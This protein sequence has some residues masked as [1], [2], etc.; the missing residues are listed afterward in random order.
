MGGVISVQQ[1]EKEGEGSKEDQEGR[2][3]NLTTRP[4]PN[5]IPVGPHSQPV[6]VIFIAEVHGPSTTHSQTRRT[7]ALQRNY[8][9]VFGKGPS[10]LWFVISL[11][12]SQIHDNSR[13]YYYQ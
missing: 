4:R 13:Y 3:R 1:D 9:V 11:P 12:S 7:N 2:L 5:N 10:K 6:D 8:E